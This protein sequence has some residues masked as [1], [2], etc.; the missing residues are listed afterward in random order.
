VTVV[1]LANLVV[2][3][4]SVDAPKATISPSELGLGE[5]TGHRRES[6]AGLI[7]HLGL[8]SEWAGPCVST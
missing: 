5:I 4:R 8:L 6:K 1:D 7:S 3:V 2:P